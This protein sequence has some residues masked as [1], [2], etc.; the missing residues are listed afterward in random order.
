MAAKFLIF[1]EKSQS[2]R[3]KPPLLPP[4]FYNYAIWIRYVLC[5]VIVSVVYYQILLILFPNLKS[6]DQSVTVKISKSRLT[7]DVVGLRR[8]PIPK[9]PKIFY[10]KTHK[11]GSSTLQNILCRYGIQ[12]DYN[13]ILPKYAGLFCIIKF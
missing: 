3:W 8:K 12:Q 9:K 4:G 6:S 2:G 10:L 5:L 1:S 11:T 7:T 13:F